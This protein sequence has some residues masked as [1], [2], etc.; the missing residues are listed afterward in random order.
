[1]NR[2]EVIKYPILTEKSYALMGQGV[3]TFAVDR[4]T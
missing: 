4:R 2:N 3:Y 1:M